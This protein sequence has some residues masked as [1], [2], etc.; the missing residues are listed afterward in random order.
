MTFQAGDSVR[1]NKFD[2]EL[3][4]SEMKMKVLRDEDEDGMVRVECTHITFIHRD[5]LERRKP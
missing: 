4:Y 3:P 2:A 5:D 1:Y